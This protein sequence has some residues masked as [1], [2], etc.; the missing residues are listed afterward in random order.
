VGDAVLAL[1]A[2]RALPGRPE[3]RMAVAHP[4]VAG[5]YRESG[6]FG[7]VLALGDAT[8]PWKAAPRLRAFRPSRAVVFTE[9]PSGGLLALLS[10]AKLRLGRAH[11]L[12][13]ICFT[14]RL[15]PATRT[16]PAWRE[17][18]EIAVAAGGIAIDRPDFR[19]E[20]GDAAVAQA[21][22]LLSGLRGFVA[23][24]P[25]A[26]YGPAKRW[27]LESW[28]ALVRALA[29]GGMPVVVIGGP[30]ERELGAPLAEAGGRDLTARTDTACAIAVLAR[31][32]VL[33]SNDSGA[34]HLARA[35]GTPVVALFGSSSP[36]WTGPSAEEGEVLRVD[37]PCS[38]CFKRVCPLRG[39]DHL[40]CLHGIQV[41][42]VI[43][44]VDR[45][46]RT[47]A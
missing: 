17:H 7:E 34:L 45:L 41:E 13:R 12:T 29:G 19:L 24:A 47:R 40:R 15:R 5:I 30:G 31:A 37:V 38:P 25:G 11:A 39:E 27:P 46:R 18:L 43:R 42:E 32:S 23:V 10:G 9:A 26:A 28:T 16:V 8:A 4:R 36:V 35:A 1:P 3:D 21:D 33:V 22:A 14:H 44:S 20:P 2:L 6:L